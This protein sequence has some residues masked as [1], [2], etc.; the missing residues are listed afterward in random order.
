MAR[1]LTN[2]ILPSLTTGEA[3]LPFSLFPPPRDVQKL[4][5]RLLETIQTQLSAVQEQITQD[6]QDPV[7]RI[8]ARVSQQTEEILQ[9]ASNVFA[10][11]PVG[12]RE[13]QY[14]IV[15][16]TDD[17]EIRD[18]A[19]YTV[20]STNILVEEEYYAPDQ[21]NLGPTSAAFNSLATYL[22]G[23]NAEKKSMT[24]TTPVTTTM[25]GEMRFYLDTE[26]PP[27]PL[28]KSKNVYE[29]GTIIIQEIPPARLAVRRF[30]GF[31][32]K[33]EITRQKQTLLTALKFD[34]LFELDV[35]H[36][37]TVGH[38]VFQYNPPYALP[39]I[40]RNEIAVPILREADT[41]QENWMDETAP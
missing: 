38:L 16:K 36:G 13:P 33:G 6:L 32:T 11:T 20:A 39:V 12:L 22:F 35:D 34:G 18:Y 10:E 24:M 25:S 41:L 31:V 8:P 37:Q 5:T 27:N 23:A 29:T 4:G 1:Q 21:R 17:Y 7:T 15:Y 14:K 40:R 3:P 9:E 30:T 19:G 2:D 28:D 26:S